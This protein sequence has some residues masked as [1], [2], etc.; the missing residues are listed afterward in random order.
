MK[1]EIVKIRE[2]IYEKNEEWISRVWECKTWSEQNENPPEGGCREL[3]IG[4][5]SVRFITFR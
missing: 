2:W 4:G 5:D 1:D 3:Y